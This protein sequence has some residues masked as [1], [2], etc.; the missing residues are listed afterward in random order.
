MEPV[1][2]RLQPG[3]VLVRFGTGTANRLSE[4]PNQFWNR[5]EPNRTSG[6]TSPSTTSSASPPP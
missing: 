2:N 4:I 1:W 5:T 3:S 6:N